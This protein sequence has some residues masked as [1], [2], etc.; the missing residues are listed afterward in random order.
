MH[1]GIEPFDVLCGYVADVLGHSERSRPWVVKEPSVAIV[2][3]VHT[4]DLEAM[5]KEGWPQY[6]ADIA[7]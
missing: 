1:N 2:A 6:R 7:V 3:A 4:N 5:F